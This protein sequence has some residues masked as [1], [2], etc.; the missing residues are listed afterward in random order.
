MPK[1]SRYQKVC[2]VF[3]DKVLSCSK[4]TQLIDAVKLMRAHNVSAIFVQEDQQICGIWTE[5]DCI[6]LD[7]TDR[8]IKHLEIHSVMSSPVLSISYSQLLSDATL[9][10]HQHNVHHLLVVDE[11]KLPCGVVSISDIVRNQG[12]DHYLQFRPIKEQ[13]H[14]DVLVVSSHCPLNEAVKMM[15]ERSEYVILVYNQQHNEHGIITQ[16][17]LLHRIITPD[18]DISCWQLAS[19]PLYQVHSKSSLFDAY[20][21]M[22]K[23]NVR[24]LVVSDEQEI[25]GVLT[26]E[27]L[28]N[29]IENAYCSELEKVLEQRD[30]ALQHSQRNLYLAN[31]IIDA[32]LDGIMITQ[33]DGVIIQ[34]NPA[35][36]VLTGYKAKEVIGQHSR[37]LSSGKHSK[38]FYIRMWQSITEKGVWQG[39]ICNRKKMAKCMLSGSPLSKYMSLIVMTLSTPLFLAILPSVKM[40]KR[41]LSSSLILMN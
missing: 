27:H 34:V 29:E 32:S 15:R 33:Q 25:K 28:I 38:S 5:A 11:N 26:L 7:F 6:K 2:D 1:S 31:K 21:L 12:L 14:K 40:Q 20:R 22:S 8:N 36:T 37:I 16:R 3:T 23:N 9:V 30:M 13:Y 35:F 18:S 10:F 41:K 24:H 19:R 39:E 4:Y 17:D